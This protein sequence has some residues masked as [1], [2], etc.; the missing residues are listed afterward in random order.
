MKWNWYK[1]ADMIEKTRIRGVCLVFCVA[2][3]LAVLNAVAL[4]QE[5][6][7]EEL[8]KKYEAI[9]GDYDFDLT[10]LG[11]ESQ[12]LSFYVEDGNLWVDSGD[13]RPAIME[14]DEDEEFKFRASDPESGN[15]EISFLKDDEGKYT[16]CSV[17]IED[18]NMEIIGV[19]IGGLQI[20]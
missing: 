1:E 3:L 9:I 13:G 8:K 10:D 19:K 14:P 11:A 17:Y 2:F 6:T 7:D 16:K 12:V 15:F 18:A 5:K 20:V 4:S